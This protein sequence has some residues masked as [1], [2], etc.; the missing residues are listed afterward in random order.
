MNNKDDVYT[1]RKEDAL[2]SFSFASSSSRHFPFSLSCNQDCLYFWFEDDSVDVQQPPQLQHLFL[3]TFLASSESVASSFFSFLQVLF[4][5]CLDSVSH[6]DHC[7]LM[8]ASMIVDSSWIMNIPDE[9]KDYM[10]NSSL[11]MEW[12]Q[13]PTYCQNNFS[14]LYLCLVSS[15]FDHQFHFFECD[16]KNKW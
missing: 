9:E 10:K 12:K 11:W 15:F 13:T 16:W 6:E 2:A 1:T 4:F 14:L 7:C 5:V 3:Y 8:F